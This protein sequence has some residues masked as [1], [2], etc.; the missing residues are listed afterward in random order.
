MSKC[1]EIG[2]FAPIVL[3]T[4]KRL[5]VTKVV[6]NAILKNP[7]AK[8]SNLIVFS[9]GPKHIDDFDKVLEVRNYLFELDGFK[10][11]EIICREKNLGLANSFINGITEVLNRFDSAIFIEDDNLVSPGF[12][13]FMNEGLRIYKEN[14]RV[15]CISGYT[16]PIWPR[17]SR[18]YFIRG[19]ETWSMATWRNRWEFFCADGKTLI[20]KIVKDNLVDKFSRDGFGFYPM[21]E[22]QIRGEIDSWGV[23]WW[24]SAFVNEMYCLYP[25]LPLCVSIGYGGESV[26]NTGGYNYLYRRP[27]ELV[28]KVDLDNFQLIVRQ[29]LRTTVSIIFM[30][31]VILRFKPRI[32]F[33]IKKLIS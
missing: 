14:L 2:P 3:F 11:V 28:A 10:S 25:H 15:G 22:S 30:N 20:D 23:R 12:L 31:S 6:I 33:L 19:A 29:T 8:A 13:A 32:L 21:L 26:H 4:H 27:S 16:Y 9:D 1:I 17:Q 5:N 18:P 24:A 7:E